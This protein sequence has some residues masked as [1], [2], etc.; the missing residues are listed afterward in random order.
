MF[1]KKSAAVVAAS[2]VGIVASLIS[3]PPLAV[4]S[5]TSISGTISLS[6]TAID[7]SVRVAAC[8]VNPEAPLADCGAASVSTMSDASTGAYAITG[9]AADVSYA[10]VAADPSEST[11]YLATF[12][13]GLT[14]VNA[15][16]S[17]PLSDT[18]LTASAGATDINITLLAISGAPAPTA[19]PTADPAASDT[20][21]AADSTPAT[22]VQA[23]AET[24][25]A[26]DSTPA[27]EVQ[28][29]AQE[30]PAPVAASAPM[31][32]PAPVMQTPVT[33]GATLPVGLAAAAAPTWSIAGWTYSIVDSLTV[34]FGVQMTNPPAGMRYA[35]KYYDVT[36]GVWTTMRPYGASNWATFKAPH[37]GTYTIYVVATD[38]SNN[39]KTIQFTW[40]ISAPPMVINGWVP[41]KNSLMSASF[42]V[43]ISNAPA[44]TT[45]EFAYY[46]VA[47]ARWVTMQKNTSNWVTFNAPHSGTYWIYVVARDILGNSTSSSMT[48][49]VPH[50]AI[51]GWAAPKPV[52]LWSTQF[53]ALVANAP[54]GT[55]YTFGYFN[56]AT[57]QWTTMQ[58]S[59]STSVIFR[60]PAAGTYSIAVTA[61][62][63]QGETATAVYS[64]W[65]APAFQFT[66]WV[67]V[68]VNR[69]TMS[70]GVASVNAP[71]N[72]LYTFTV[73]DG[74]NRRYTTLRA[75]GTSNWITYQASHAGDYWM[76]V[77]A[78][79]GGYTVWT[80][81]YHFRIYNM[82]IEWIDWTGLSV[83]W[84]GAVIAH[85]SD[86]PP[87]A[88]YQFQY[89]DSTYGQWY[90]LQDWSTSNSTY[91]TV[92]HAGWWYIS[93]TA[94]Y[95]TGEQLQTFIDGPY[96]TE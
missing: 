12:Y 52:D 72:A 69:S 49:V 8:P 62:T 89:Y 53:T 93:V 77:S 85:V 91:L 51:T 40:Q 94:R 27:T 73:Y 15:S 81:S 26:A 5:P 18:V 36:R 92:G 17:V 19:T 30:P 65:K 29:P 38:T 50:I 86:A 3:A 23:P 2:V 9:L 1:S 42:G 48:W 16:S 41:V 6:D 45:Y 32:A 87:G 11:Q 59:T 56:T 60:A 57:G 67:V 71:S 22:E 80:S 20:P 33:T 66:G 96:L 47:W 4:A 25:A 54:A 88:T 79:V 21:A 83:D 76:N 43:A 14:L 90:V 68:P 63:P 28:T 55:I 39:S 70:F 35:F 78:M 74:V 44:G 82:Q 24:P 7:R 84:W 95:P 61:W 58:K 10:V 31:A 46:D 34:S 64:P 37:N 75:N 13:G